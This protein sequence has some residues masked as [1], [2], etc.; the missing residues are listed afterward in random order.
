MLTCKQTALLVSQSHDRRL[1]WRE[2]LGMHMHL[3]FCRA[4]VR[5]ERQIRFLHEAAR[6]FAL[7]YAETDEQA[8]LS[9]EA[10]ERIARELDRYA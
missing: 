10:I 7:G 3:I 5:F 4:C 6:R 9:T 8:Q 2:W 1:S